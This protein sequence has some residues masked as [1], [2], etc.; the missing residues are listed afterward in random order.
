[1]QKIKV[2]VVDDHTIVRDGICALLGL[3]PD[4]EVVEEAANGKEALEIVRKLLPDVV[5]MDI[6]MPIMDGLEATRRIHKDF[7]GQRCWY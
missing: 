1:M 6:A 5:L 4:I 7:P 3:T 2:L